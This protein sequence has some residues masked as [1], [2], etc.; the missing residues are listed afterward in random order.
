MAQLVEIKVGC[1]HCGLECDTDCITIDDKNFCCQGCKMVY[2]ILDE[3]DLCE[4]YTYDK[5]PGTSLR[6]VSEE[7]Y[8][9]L[10]D[11]SIRK[12][13]LAFDSATFS[14]VQF[15]IPAI[16]CISCIW[17]LENLQRLNAGILKSEVSFSRKQAVI[18]FNPSI[19]SLA[20]VARLLAAIGYAPTINL[21]EQ[22]KPVMDRS[23]V[24]KLTI[25]G[26]CFGNI[27]LLSFPEYLGLDGSEP[28]LK[29]LFAYLNFGL[30]LPVIL[31]C[32]QDYF[33]NAWTGS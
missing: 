29:I 8:A 28:T 9:F 23:L 15:Y 2:E 3:N 13:V 6:F 27:M 22:K 5:T 10:E 12:K 16:H 20:K 1:F 31:Y 4:Y 11:S 21:E 14:T 30:S 32:G 7:S 19:I 17:L 26:F 24:M 33:I 18:N 25:A